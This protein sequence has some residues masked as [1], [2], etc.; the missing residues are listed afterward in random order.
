MPETRNAML[1]DLVQESFDEA[2]FLWSRWEEALAS[3]ARDLAGVSF[4]V[5]E[6]LFG[7]LDGIRLG[8]EDV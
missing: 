7:S 2:A 3:H 8:G 4:W 6:R 5:E 1:W